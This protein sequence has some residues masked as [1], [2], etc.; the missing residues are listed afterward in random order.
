LFEALG[1]NALT[2]SVY[3]AMLRHPDA[4]LADIARQLDVDL[5][6]LSE[7]LDD[8]ER[9]S[10]LRTSSSACAAA[11]Q[12]VR[13]EVGLAVL[14]AREQA[15]LARRQQRIEESTAAFASLLSSR[16]ELPPEEPDV[17]VQ[18]L[19][20]VDGIRAR[21]GDLAA[22]AQW[23]WCSFLPGGCRTAAGPPV[24]WTPDT[25]AIDR[26]VRVRAVYLDTIRNDQPTLGH[27]T[28]LAELCA[29]VR[30]APSLPLA[31]LVVDRSTAVVPVDGGSGA[32]TALV[33]SDGGMVAALVA[34]FNFVWK[35]AQPVGSPRRRQPEGPSSRDKEV[36]SMLAAGHTDE[37]V[38]RRLGVSAR[39][40]RRLASD[41]LNRL[42]ARSRFQAGVMAAT[43]GWIGP[44]D[45][46]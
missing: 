2:E 18:R 22:S 23:E 6:E 17:G 38:A 10:L 31:F 25:E 11:V 37:A 26:G 5:A 40:A 4:D 3:L 21:T 15:G 7:T 28:R 19:V 9:L 32:P 1:L 8:L 44:D 42:R 36:L 39:T 45:T 43:R 30:T 13:P 14:L 16:R 27:V 20:G 46:G 12:P 29:E 35:T 34:L 24:H 41:L 33:L